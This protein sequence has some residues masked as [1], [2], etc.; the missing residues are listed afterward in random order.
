MQREIQYLFNF[1][2]IITNSITMEKEIKLLRVLIARLGE[3]GFDLEAWKSFTIVI[4]SR[5]FGDNSKKITQIEKIEYDYSSWSLRDTSGTSHM[6][7]CKKLG[8]QVLEAAILEIET[9]GLPNKEPQK[10][11]KFNID[12]IRDALEN[13]LSHS[14]LRELKKILNSGDEVDTIKKNLT[15]KLKVFGGDVSPKIIASIIINPQIK[16]EI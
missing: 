13:E 10:R 4:L 15:D 12:V 11:G 8:Q 7:T 2:V 5:I 16:N 1:T 14:E 6:E 3:E 9:L